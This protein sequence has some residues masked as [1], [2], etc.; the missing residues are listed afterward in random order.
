MEE[1]AMNKTLSN[2]TTENTSTVVDEVMAET[3]CKHHPDLPLL[4][5]MA[6]CECQQGS[7][8]NALPAL[9][10]HGSSIAIDKNQKRGTNVETRPTRYIPTDI[11]ESLLTRMN[12]KDAVRLSVVCKDWRAA[13]RLFDPTTRRTPWL[14][15]AKPMKTTCRLQSIVDKEVSFE[16]EFHG[17]PTERAYF[18]YCSHG[19]LASIP[20]ILNPMH[21]VNPF[22]GKWL[23]LPAHALAPS[24]LC[25]SSA[26][27]TRDCVLLARDYDNFLYVWRPGDESWTKFEGPFQ[28]FSTIISFEGQFYAWDYD[29]G[30]LTV[31]QVLPFRL[32][33]LSVPCPISF[34]SHYI[35]FV[36]LVEC[37]GNI[38]LVIV[39]KLSHGSLSIYLYR[40]D[41]ENKAW[42]KMES[43]GDRA[44]FV[45][46]RFFNP[47]ISVSA[48]EV[49]CHAN[50]VYI[51][52]VYDV[53]IYDMDNH[54]IESFSF[55]QGPRSYI[56]G[57]IWITPSLN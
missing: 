13:T 25:M 53:M 29:S 40:L 31:L 57:P 41:M 39:T 8:P 20:G 24:F 11:V 18:S 30:L 46:Y 37:C 35:L 14:I 51:N 3:T 2:T 7:N 26:P 55:R 36:R 28:H 44:L 19:W 1:A 56:G 48:S 9:G 23:Q 33:E 21:L 16:I 6:N 43:L 5:Q 52:G 50:C 10:L 47:A 49:G 54:M 45:D 4:D 15:I 27:T 22:S 38:L 12:P 32:R 42:I 17:F 34:T